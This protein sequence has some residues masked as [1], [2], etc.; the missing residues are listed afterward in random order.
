M[1]LS[2]AYRAEGASREAPPETMCVCV[3]INNLIC[4]IVSRL[5]KEVAVLPDR[6]VCLSL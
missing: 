1:I 6:P 3:H 2:A 4:P 5:E